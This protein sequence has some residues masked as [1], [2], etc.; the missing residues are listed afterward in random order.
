MQ[1]ESMKAV[2]M[3][4][5]SFMLMNLSCNAAMRQAYL[6]FLN[7]SLLEYFCCYYVCKYNSDANSNN[8]TIKQK[9]LKLVL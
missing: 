7:T 9:L 3:M 2:V 1:E 5:Q 8:K 6:S 4:R